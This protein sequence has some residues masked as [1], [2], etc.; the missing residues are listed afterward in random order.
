LEDAG[1]DIALDEV[2]LFASGG[3]QGGG[4]ESVGV[5]QGASRGLMEDGEGVGGEDVLG[6]ADAGEPR[7]QVVVGVIGGE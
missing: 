5:A 1:Q 7:A 6:G 4:G 3:A 2:F